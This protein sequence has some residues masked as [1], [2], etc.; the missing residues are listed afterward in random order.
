VAVAPWSALRVL[1]DAGLVRPV[2]PDR[3]WG[4]AR[5]FR[6]WGISLAAGFTAAASLHPD[7]VAVVDERGTLTWA[8]LDARAD[9]VAA[10][11][12]ARGVGPR[13]VSAVLA[14]NHRGF[15]LAT[16]ALAKVGADVVYLNTSFA[17]PQLHEVLE[18]ER[19]TTLVYDGDFAD[20]L[21]ARSGRVPRRFVSWPAT[22]GPEPGDPTLDDLAGTSAPHPPA[23]DRVPR[24]VILTSGTTGSP[25]GAPRPQ[26]TGLGTAVA[27]LERIPYR[28]GETMVV[29]APL[30]H[31]W[32]F[33]HLG[34]GLLLG[35][36]MVLLGGRFDAERTLT[37]VAEHRAECL[38]AVP[39]MLQ[40]ILDLP[41]DIRQ[42]HDTSSLRVVPLS[43][44]SIPGDLATR[45]MDEM[46]E[47]LY[48]LYGSTEVGWATI[49]TPADLRDE[50]GTA[51]RPPLGTEVRVLDDAGHGVPAGRVGRI[52]VRSPLVFEGYT[53]GGTKETV[54]GLMS[55]GDLGRFDAEGRLF[56]EG[57]DDEMIVSG[58]ENVFPREVEDLLARHPEVAEVAVIGVP[59]D[60]FG[61]ALQAFVVP[62]AAGALTVDDV[63]DHVSAHLARFKV[64]RRV[65][66]VDELPRN[67]TGKIVKRLLR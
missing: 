40:R 60:E 56:I 59:D 38:V 30:F 8:E 32:G 62:R 55:T 3:V 67:P 4:V 9:A 34:M 31:S 26:T 42:R 6:R 37:A 2:R 17:G 65:S 5:A 24:V 50:P 27:L 41:T 22:E 51:G 61:Q 1:F 23:P 57:R 14:R 49:A 46:G 16:A 33:A 25:K 53:G 18:R 47:N 63:R 52:F 35:A 43:G 54:D 44:S 28:D 20:L 48:N 36:T 29:A 21:D 15:V 11:L 13:E 10:G 58:G 19:V 39:V 45:W 64:P 7:R 12:A 66:I